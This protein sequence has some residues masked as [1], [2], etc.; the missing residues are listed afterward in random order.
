MRKCLRSGQCHISGLN[1]RHTIL[2]VISSLFF[3]DEYGH[4]ANLIDY[5][6]QI[7]K[8]DRNIILNI[9]I[10]CLIDR[11]DRKSHSAVCISM[12]QTALSMSVNINQR[13]S[14]E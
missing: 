6:Y 7:I 3:T 5:I 2:S 13:V 10:I 11:V 14:Q 12:A 1:I 8:A 9:K 4:T